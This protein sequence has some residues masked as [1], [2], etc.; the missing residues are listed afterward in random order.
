MAIDRLGFGYPMNFWDSDEYVTLAL[1]T[2]TYFLVFEG[3]CKFHESLC[4][5]DNFSKAS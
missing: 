1:K 4:S 3:P 5:L 2:T